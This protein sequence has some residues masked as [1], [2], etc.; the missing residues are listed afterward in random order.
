M[1]GCNPERIVRFHAVL[2]SF[3]LHDY[4]DANFVVFPV[5]A[6]EK[7]VMSLYARIDAV[8]PHGKKLAGGRIMCH[9][10]AI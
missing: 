6:K 1:V 10:V 2:V 7:P 5:D 9:W 8:N 3:A 4:R